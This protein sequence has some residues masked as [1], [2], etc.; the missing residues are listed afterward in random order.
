MNIIFDFDGTLTNNFQVVI[1]SMNSV[2]KKLNYPPLSEQNVKKLGIKA[3]FKEYKISGLK[4]LLFVFLARKQIA[5]YVDEYPLPD[6][7]SDTIKTLSKNN[8]LAI[9]TSNS[10]KTV[11]KF[12]DKHDLQE[13]FEEI[14]SGSYFG[15]ERKIVKIIKNHGWKKSET[16]YVGDEERDIEAGKKAGLKA[17]GVSWG[18]ESPKLLQKAGANKIFKQPS[19]ILGI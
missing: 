11:K 6:K 17:Y 1:K 5:K 2:L 3:L 9:V 14:Y 18:F 15:K 8:N 19:E 16:V 13:Y 12:L 10:S 4:L 7:M